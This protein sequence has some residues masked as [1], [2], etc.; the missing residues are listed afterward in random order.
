MFWIYY[1]I[2]PAA[3]AWKWRDKELV[4][5]IYYL[6][7]TMLSAFLAV[8][9]EAPIRGSIVQLLGRLPFLSSRW[10]TPLSMVLIWFIVFAVW[11]AV[12]RRIAPDG[13]N[14]FTPPEK[15]SKIL[16]PVVIFLHGG[17]VCALIFT[18]LSAMP[19]ESYTSPVTKDPALCSGARYRLLWNSF[20]IDR[21]SFQP[22]GVTA[23][24]QAFDR[25][26]PEEATRKSEQ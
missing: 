12:L 4:P 5:S 18:I 20:F 21:A 1:Y 22:A 26:V 9:C 19:L 17:I 2:L 11:V 14:D 3:A 6:Y 7:G 13:L 10:A 24:R 8:W 25:F 23:R 15:V 16:T